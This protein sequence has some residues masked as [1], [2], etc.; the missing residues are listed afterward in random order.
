MPGFEEDKEDKRGSWDPN[1]KDPVI[2]KFN[3][4]GPPQWEENGA[5]KIAQP[6]GIWKIPSVYGNRK[7]LRFPLRPQIGPCVRWGVF[8]RA[9]YREKWI[10]NPL[11][12]VVPDVDPLAFQV[13]PPQ[14]TQI[15]Q[16][17]GPPFH[18]HLHKAVAS[19][20]VKHCCRIVDPEGVVRRSKG[21]GWMCRKWV[22][23][24]T[25]RDL[26]NHTTEE[27]E[28]L[29][30]L[31]AARE[32]KEEAKFQALMRTIFA[33]LANKGVMK[34]AAEAISKT[35]KQHSDHLAAMYKLWE[36]QVFH[37]INDQIS[38]K[39]KRRSPDQIMQKLRYQQMRYCK[40]VNRRL[41]FRDTLNKEY[42]PFEL[43]GTEVHYSTKDMIDPVKHDLEKDKRER[44]F[45]GDSVFHKVHTKDILDP[46][47]WTYAKFRSTMHGHVNADN[48]DATY[49]P[50]EMIPEKWYSRPVFWNRTWGSECW[51]EAFPPGGKGMPPKPLDDQ[52]AVWKIELDMVWDSP[53]KNQKKLMI[54]EDN[55]WF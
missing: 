54:S 23:R 46:T 41:V 20:D 6:D 55:E 27:W 7:V 14:T 22:D 44:V 30:E 51:N 37:N 32:A 38:K 50:R 4:W 26:V 39:L 25:P 52:E 8:V 9:M 45:R 12:D 11:D 48:E 47:F 42:D 24:P 10:T 33:G 40:Q 16:P 19:G 18:Y 36:K 35:D 15:P 17:K 49:K 1:Y 13:R 34:D 43:Q 5:V 53:V 31:K 29:L 3:P 21:G 28:R 2:W